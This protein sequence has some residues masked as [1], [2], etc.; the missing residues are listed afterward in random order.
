METAPPKVLTEKEKLES[1]VFWIANDDYQVQRHGLLYDAVGG[2]I[3]GD[4]GVYDFSGVILFTTHAFLPP[5]PEKY[6]RVYIYHGT[7]NKPKKIVWGK[8]G[9]TMYDYYFMAGQKDLWA[10]KKFGH[11]IPRKKEVKIGNTGTDEFFSG[12]WNR[13]KAL[14]E[15]KITDDRPIAMYCPTY[16]TGML[17]AVSPKLKPL[18]KHYHVVLKPHPRETFSKQGKE[19]VRWA[20]IYRGDIKK[21]LW[22]VDLFISDQSSVAYDFTVAGK[23]IIMVFDQKEKSYA[24]PDQYNLFKHTAVWNPIIETDILSKIFEAEARVKEVLKLSRDSFYFTDG[25]AS[26]R[27]AAWVHN[28]AKEYIKW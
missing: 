19:K 26:E 18:T 4:D 20:K 1:K 6:T 9:R 27:A 23:P 16:G 11:Y 7:S 12:A 21:V 3:A 25:K 17:G 13:E 28:K 14:K 8:M 15:L 24:D 22:A 2:S 5:K 10:M